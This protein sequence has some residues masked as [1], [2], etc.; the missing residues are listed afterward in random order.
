[1]EI[2]GEWPGRIPGATIYLSGYISLAG[3]VEIHMHSKRADGSRFAIIDMIGTLRD[4]RID[5]AGG[6]LNGRHVT[7]NW[8]RTELRQPF[9]S[10][11]HR[12]L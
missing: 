2:S 1:V 12:W 11:N 10:V 4:G 5:A 6:F 8:R 9:R 3:D 7:L